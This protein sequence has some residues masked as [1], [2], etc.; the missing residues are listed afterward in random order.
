MKQY[1]IVYIKSLM[2][3]AGEFGGCVVIIAWGSFYRIFSSLFLISP[4]SLKIL[5]DPISAFISSTILCIVLLETV[6][7]DA[8]HDL[9]IC[10]VLLYIVWASTVVNPGSRVISLW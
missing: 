6:I 1:Q 9:R 2:L 10:L 4:V 5:S 3:T 8:A 7:P